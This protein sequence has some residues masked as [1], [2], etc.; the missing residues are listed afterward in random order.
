MLRRERLQ[1]DIFLWTDLKNILWCDFIPLMKE[2]IH[3]FIY[4]ALFSPQIKRQFHLNPKL[5]D[6]TVRVL[7][8]THSHRDLIPTWSR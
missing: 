7:G 3:V 2:E 1:C 6:F 8:S 5:I 4:K